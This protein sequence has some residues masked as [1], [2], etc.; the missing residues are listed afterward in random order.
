MART[1]LRSIATK[2]SINTAMVL[3]LSEYGYRERDLS[4]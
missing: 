1:K 3:I 4:R 2:A